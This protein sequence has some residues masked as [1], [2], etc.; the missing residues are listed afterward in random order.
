MRSLVSFWNTSRVIGGCVEAEI[1][2][3]DNEMELHSANEMTRNE[4]KGEKT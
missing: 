2:R 1:R 4:W 3:I